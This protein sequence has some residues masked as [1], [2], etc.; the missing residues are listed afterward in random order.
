[1][2]GQGLQDGFTIL[3]VLVALV[4]AAT[5]SAIIF[6]HLRTLVDLNIRVRQHQQDVTVTLNEAAYLLAPDWG[7]RARVSLGDDRVTIALRDKFAPSLYVSNFSLEADD[8]L[9]PLTRAFTPYQIYRVQPGKRY[10]VS[11]LF[12]NLPLDL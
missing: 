6:S 10:H 3:E 7:Q 4:I 9:P 5:A 11:L 12:P 2:T 1:L 8:E